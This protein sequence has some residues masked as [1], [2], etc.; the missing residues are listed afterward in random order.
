MESLMNPKIKIKT[1]QELKKIVELFK[2]QHKIVVLANGCFDLLHVGHVRYLE[3]SKRLGDVLIVAMNS[4]ASMRKI[5]DAK[6]P[7]MPV[8]ARAEIVAAL[9][10][11]D[12]VVLFGQER[13]DKVIASLKPD[14][15]AKGTDYTINTVPEK[16]LV[17]S[18]GGRVAVVGDKKRHATRDV[19]GQIVKKYGRRL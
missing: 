8:Q 16:S 19:I 7:I 14:I 1:L 6:R 17:I 12:Y 11:V 5:K 3:A 4:D 9:A 2:Y 10:A 18:Y 15:Q 13:A